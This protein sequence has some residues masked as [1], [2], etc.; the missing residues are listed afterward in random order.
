MNDA[1][2][3]EVAKALKDHERALP[4]FI[5]MFEKSPKNSKGQVITRVRCTCGRMNDGKPE[6]LPGECLVMQGTMYFMSCSRCRAK[7][8]ANWDERAGR[9]RSRWTGHFVRDPWEGEDA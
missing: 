5:E 8:D 1:A 4:D 3:A 7:M 9:Y 6:P 2:W